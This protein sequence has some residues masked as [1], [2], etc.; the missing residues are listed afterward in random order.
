MSTAIERHA[1]AT[2]GF[3]ERVD[4]AALRLQEAASQHA[5]RIVLT[6]SLGAEDM[7]LADLIAQH[8][9]PIALATLETGRLHAETLALLPLIE[10]RYGI[11]VER[12][13]PEPDAAAAFVQAHGPMAMRDSVALRKACCRIRKLEP[14][15]RALAGR[16][17]WVTGLRREQS[18]ARAEV[19]FDSIDDE[20]RHKFS[21][22][23]DWS[24]HDVWYY[25]RL[26]EVPYNRLHDHFY[27][28]IGCEPCTRPVAIGEDLRAGRWWWEREDAKECGLHTS[29]R[30]IPIALARD[31]S[32]QQEHRA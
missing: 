22:L 17:A 11:V 3:D 26:H 18:D 28:S 13:Q 15:A 23:A 30:A 1:R 25:I 7:V 31:S 8:Q 14:L 4:A 10:S 16:S 20:G 2:A 6:T 27:P 9:L 21:P 32:T 12:W 19:P 29:Q 5:G 24:W